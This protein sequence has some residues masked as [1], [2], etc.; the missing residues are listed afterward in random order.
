LHPLFDPIPGARVFRIE[1]RLPAVYVVGHAE[2]LPDTQALN[3]IFEP[4]VLAAGTA[5]LAPDATASIGDAGKAGSCALEAYATTHLQARCHADRP[6]YAIFT[7]QYDPG[8][9]ATVDGKVTG[10]VRAN[11]VM[12]AVPLSTGD[13]VIH[14]DYRAPGLKLG[15]SVTLA[16]LLGLAGLAWAGKSEA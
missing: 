12:R 11:L 1:H 15:L 6:G 5:W 2:P 3:R 10:I 4:S 8:W 16:A 14:L 7:E 9:T 13:H